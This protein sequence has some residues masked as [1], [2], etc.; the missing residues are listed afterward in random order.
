LAQRKGPVPL[1]RIVFIE[2]VSR[3]APALPR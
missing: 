3:S 1:S 2:K